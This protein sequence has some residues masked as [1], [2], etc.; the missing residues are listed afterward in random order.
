MRLLSAVSLIALCSISIAF[1]ETPPQTAGDYLKRGIERF[2]A[3][4]IAES[5]EDFDQAA[6]LDP[7]LAAQLWQRGI[8][9]YY[10]GKFQ[11]G[12]EQFE[13][14]K[15]VNPNDVENAAWH[16]ACVAR[17]GGLDSARKSLMK[18][19][20]AQ[21]DRVPMREIYA[22]YAGRGSEADV[23]KAA[24]KAGTEEA[25]MYAHLYLGLYDEVT[26]KTDAA[27]DQMRQAASA[28]LRAN[29][30]HDVAKVHV[31]ERRWN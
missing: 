23:M 30:M 27:R 25:R 6:R 24:E 11:E 10:A 1:A 29:Y 16:F 13:L 4:K 2:R 3:D 20:L 28:R 8:S 31:L 14:H 17:I 21:D 5:I 26:G 9:D 15:T 12:K 7:Q 18:I 19:D 22:L